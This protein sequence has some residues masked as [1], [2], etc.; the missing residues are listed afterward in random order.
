MWADDV[1][2]IIREVLER[3]PREE[4]GLRDGSGTPEG[5]KV[6]GESRS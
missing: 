5:L 6:S 4:A 2:G 1:E 3:Y